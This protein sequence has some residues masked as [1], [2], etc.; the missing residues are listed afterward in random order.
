MTLNRKIKMGKGKRIK[1]KKDKREMQ[2]SNERKE[3]VA[4]KIFC[5]ISFNIFF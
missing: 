2:K 5:D 4:S 3:P 1:N